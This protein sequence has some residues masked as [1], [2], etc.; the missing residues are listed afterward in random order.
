LTTQNLKVKEINNFWSQNDRIT[1]YE[2]IGEIRIY[3]HEKIIKDGNKNRFEF[4]H[5]NTPLPGFTLDELF[6]IAQSRNFNYT[7]DE[8]KEAFD[9]LRNKKYFEEICIYRKETRYE[10]KDPRFFHLIIELSLLENSIMEKMWITWIYKRSITKNERKWLV[11]CKG[12][13]RYEEDMKDLKKD[14]SMYKNFKSNDEIQKQITKKI[15]N[16]DKRITRNF[17]SLKREYFSEIERYN[18]PYEKFIDILYPKIVQGYK[19]NSFF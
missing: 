9:T 7:K 3:K 2:K 13:N 17:R 18:F 6:E 12:I 16:L 10:I 11:F 15:I 19:F 4:T 1:Y 5:Y 8:I 14:K